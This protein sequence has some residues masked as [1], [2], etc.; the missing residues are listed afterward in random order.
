MIRKRAGE[1]FA[2]AGIDFLDADAVFVGAQLHIVED[3]HR[4]H[5]E[6]HLLRQLAAQRL[7]LVGDAMALHIVDQRQQAV[8][9][10]DAQQIE[11]QRGGDRFF[12]G[13]GI[14]LGSWLPAA[15]VSAARG[16]LAL[17]GVPGERAGAGRK[18]RRTRG[19]ACR[20]G[21]R[22]CPSRRRPCRAPGDRRRAGPSAPCRWRLRR[23]PWTPSGRRRWR[24]SAPASGD[25]RPSPTVSRVKVWRGV[26]EAHALLRHAR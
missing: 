19:S 5:D 9:Q 3:A 18:A 4:R 12:L 1:K 13:R 25:T 10:F 2:L 16:V 6:A 8:A 17:V 11:R 22:Q 7:D 24:R 20:A 14:G 15:C 21:P 23:R 26:A